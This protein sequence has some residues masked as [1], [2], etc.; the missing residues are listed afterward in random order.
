MEGRS[1]WKK[2]LDLIYPPRCVI[3]GKALPLNAD[4]L[5][6]ACAKGASE[7]LRRYLAVGTHSVECRAPWRYHGPIRD[8]IFRF[9]FHGEHSLAA[10]FGKQMAQCASGFLPLDAVVP[11]PVSEPRLRERGYDQSVLLAQALAREIDVPC[12]ELLRKIRDNPAQHTLPASKRAEN[13]RDAYRADGAANGLRI[14]LV[15]DIV[16]TGET[17]R[18][19]AGAL[20]DAGAVRVSVCALAFSLEEDRQGGPGGAA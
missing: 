13:V 14:L 19:A 17:V 9:K 6:A 20:F 16:T 4:G 2:L 11:L 18:S 10:S 1:V 3:C 12:R 7:R 5:C 15:D 8:A